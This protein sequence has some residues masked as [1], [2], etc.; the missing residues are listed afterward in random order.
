M[1]N[2][3]FNPDELKSMAE[4]VLA[5]AK[6]LGATA[7]EA[8]IAAHTGF[9]I[10][11]RNAQTEE[12][13][14]HRNQGMGITV[15]NGQKQGT[16]SCSDLTLPALQASVTAAW[17]IAKQ[18]SADP[19]SGLADPSLLAQHFPDLQVQCLARWKD[20]T[21]NNLANQENAVQAN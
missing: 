17:A 8:S 11:V 9:S 18:T 20:P 6:Q 1:S 15:Y 5:Y 13:I 4:S 16:A 14:Y 12:L 19:H 3:L 21:D 2:L 10:N 7:A